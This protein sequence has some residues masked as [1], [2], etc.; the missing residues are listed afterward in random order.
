MLFPDSAKKVIAETFYD[1]VVAVLDKLESVDSEG[2]VVKD[3]W[4]AKSTFKCNVRFTALSEVQS[5]LGL[6]EEIDV[7]ITCPTDTAVE[8]DDILQYGGFKYIATEVLPRDSHKL[9][10][11]RKWQE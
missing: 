9:I 2:G 10:V 11:G 1:K 4:E 8:V 7:A 3:G 5:E 6:T